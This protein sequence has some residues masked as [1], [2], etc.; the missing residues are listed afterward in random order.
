VEDLRSS[1]DIS[2]VGEPF[3][4]P[5]RSKE[6]GKE[7]KRE[8]VAISFSGKFPP[9]TMRPRGTK[10]GEGEQIGKTA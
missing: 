9:E 8:N 5:E 2:V 4:K 1:K 10:T 7:S 3:H 6:S